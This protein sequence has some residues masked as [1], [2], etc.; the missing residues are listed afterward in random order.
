MPGSGDSVQ[1]LKAGIPRESLEALVEQ[2]RALTP[3]AVLAMAA[4]ML[5]LYVASS[6]VGPAL[7]DGE[8]VMHSLSI[9]W[10][11]T[12]KYPFAAIGKIVGG[13]LLSAIFASMVDICSSNPASRSRERPSRAV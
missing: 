7:W 6:I 3:A 10:H 11:I 1:A 2:G 5:A 12:R 9:T 8:R 13:M 4:L